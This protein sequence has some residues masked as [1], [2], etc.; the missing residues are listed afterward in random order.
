MLPELADREIKR[1]RNWPAQA[2]T[3]KLGAFKFR[4]L[5]DREQARLGSKFD[6]RQFHH[7]V[8]KFGPLPL[9]VLEQVLTQTQVQA[10]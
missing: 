8:L 9:D 6:I 7:D 3:Y 1:V 10:H 5:R 2:I 4:Q